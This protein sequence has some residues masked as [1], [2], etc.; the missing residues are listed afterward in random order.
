MENPRVLAAA[1]SGHF[2][3]QTKALLIG[4]FGREMSIRCW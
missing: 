4:I 3:V 1:A 2:V